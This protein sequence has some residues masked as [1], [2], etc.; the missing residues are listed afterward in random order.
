[1]LVCL[2]RMWTW[3]KLYW[4][5]CKVEGTGRGRS[6]RFGRQRLNLDFVLDKWG[7]Y[8]FLHSSP[9]FPFFLCEVL[10]IEPRAL[11]T[12]G[13][14]SMSQLYLLLFFFFLLLFILREGLTK[15]LRLALNSISSS[16]RP[17]TYNLPGSASWVTRLQVFVTT[18]ASITVSPSTG[19]LWKAG[20]EADKS[21]IVLRIVVVP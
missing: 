4:S 14:C 19:M 10:R 21:V 1:M 2:A 8:R 13:K 9:P 5:R 12:L 20:V 3:S 11:H 7:H 17:W 15:L 16:G 18:L 6:Q